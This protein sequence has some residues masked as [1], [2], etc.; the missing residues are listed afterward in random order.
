VEEL[1]RLTGDDVLIT[2]ATRRL[3][4]LPYCGFAERPTMA[5]KG[6][7]E[8]VRIYAPLDAAAAAQPA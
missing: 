3:L 8:Q 2:E 7:S 1:T 5:L 4:T 6:K